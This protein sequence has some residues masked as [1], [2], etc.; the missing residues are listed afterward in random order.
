MSLLINRTFALVVL[1]LLGYGIVHGFDEVDKAVCDAYP[2]PAERREC[3]SELDGVAKPQAQRRKSVASPP[4]KQL[5]RSPSRYNVPEIQ[6]R[7][8]DTMKRSFSRG[9]QLSRDPKDWYFETIRPKEVKL[10]N[11]DKFVQTE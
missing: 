8:P 11:G 5:S 1:S 3:Y 9:T 2:T 4:P 7:L 6:I 10:I